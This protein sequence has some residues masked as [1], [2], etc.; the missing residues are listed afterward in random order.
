MSPVAFFSFSS[1]VAPI[2]KQCV[3]VCY[4]TQPS[5][6][7]LFDLKHNVVDACTSAPLDV[8]DT[9]FPSN[10]QDTTQAAPLK[11]SEPAFNLLVRS[12]G[13]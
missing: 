6:A 7:S 13:L 2:S 3:D 5:P 8:C 12:P 9:L 10:L 1:L 11:A 4:M